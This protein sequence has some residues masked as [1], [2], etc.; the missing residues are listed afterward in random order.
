MDAPFADIAFLASSPNRVGV[1]ETLADGPRARHAL[2][3]ELEI[4]QP[5]ASRILRDLQKRNW[6]DRT[7]AGYELTRLGELTICAFTQLREQ[8]ETIHHL[9]DVAAMLPE[10]GFDFDLSRLRTAD[11]VRIAQGDSGLA[12]TYE[13]AQLESAEHVRILTAFVPREGV[14]T[15]W[16]QVTTGDQH[17]ELVVAASTV[18]VIRTDSD[19]ARWT[20]E[21]LT[22]DRTDIYQYEGDVA[23]PI[24][25]T[26]DTVHLALPRTDE[27]DGAWISSNDEQVLDWAVATFTRHK[28]RAVRLTADDISTEG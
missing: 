7:E 12:R 28:E 21:M 23:Y 20:R 17:F 9:S 22:S 25:I 4:S 6:I 19:L 15:S 24:L 26:D 16:R 1:L 13:N 14:K 3:A 18:P 8:L 10:N 5:T 27:T 11:I 2:Q